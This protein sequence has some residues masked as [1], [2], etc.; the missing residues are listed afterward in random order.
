MPTTTTQRIVG[1]KEDL[2]RDLAYVNVNKAPLYL[3]LVTMGNVYPTTATK[4]SWVDYTSEG[5][6]TTLATQVSS[7]GETTF[8]VADGSIFTKDCLAAIGVEIVKVT[9]ISGNTLTVERAKHATSAGA[10]YKEG[11]EIYYINDNLEEGADLIGATYKPGANFDNV[12][13]IIR[14]EISVSGTAEAIEIP[15][16]GG[17]D[18][19]S[20]EQLRKMDKVIG[21]IEKAVVSGVKFEDGNRRGMDGVKTMLKKGQVVD[22]SSGEISLALFSSLLKK[23]YNIGADLTGGTYAFYV[24]AVQKVKISELLKKYVEA[25]TDEET[26]GAVANYINTD[27]GKFPLILSNN[28]RSDE[29]MFVNHD[30]IK[31]RPLGDRGLIHEYM[32]KTGDNTK[33]L[34]LSELTVEMRNIHTMGLITNLA[35]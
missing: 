16:A 2:S 12:T 21:K 29:I 30:D 13:Q 6:Q 22:A 27:F 7:T 4:I 5:T 18:A 15:S 14:E 17:Y 34:I 33:G 10:S 25:S 28:L 23:L 8:T 35:K 1:K 20:L 19:Y 32:G 11:E 26:L 31:L 24:S 9:N 3:N